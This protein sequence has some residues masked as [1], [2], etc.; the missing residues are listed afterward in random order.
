MKKRRKDD[1]VRRLKQLIRRKMITKIKQSKKIYDR[2][3]SRG[4]DHII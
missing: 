2:K 4:R 1:G 3:K